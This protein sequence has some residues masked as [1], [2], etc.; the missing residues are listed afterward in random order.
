MSERIRRYPG[1]DVM[2][3]RDGPSWNDATRH[4][5]DARRAPVRGPRLL[6]QEQWQVL[7]A[8]CARI[9]PQ[10]TD[11]PPVPLPDLVEGRLFERGSDGYRDARLPAPLDAYRLGLDALDVAARERHDSGFAALGGAAQDALL[12]AAQDGALDGPAWKGMPS[13]LFFSERL[14]HDITSAYYA[15]PVAWNE[16]GFGG[17]ASPRGYVRMNFNKRDAWEAAEASD[18]SDSA[19]ARRIEEKN[20]RVR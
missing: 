18:A 10:P 17:P 1:Y 13:A 4:A 5:I 16:I 2:S 8:A 15:D 7:C 19:D 14:V 6:T 11:R 3:K 20:R 9:V 12:Q